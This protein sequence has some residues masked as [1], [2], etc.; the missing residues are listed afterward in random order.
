MEG[1]II[2]ER[3]G[4]NILLYIFLFIPRLII[5]LINKIKDWITKLLFPSKKLEEKKMEQEAEMARLR[6]IDEKAFEYANNVICRKV[7]A[8]VHK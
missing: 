3:N 4:E 8:A 7:N 6:L 2:P 5:N 1:D